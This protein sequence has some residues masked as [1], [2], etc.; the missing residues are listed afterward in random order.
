MYSSLLQ[1]QSVQY[2][3]ESKS[4]PEKMGSMTVELISEGA[5]EDYL[6]RELKLTEASVR[7]K[8]FIAMLMHD[9]LSLTPSLSYPPSFLPSLPRSFTPSS[10]LHPSPFPL[11]FTP[12]SSL[13]L[14]VA[15]PEQ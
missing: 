11:S 15:R 8:T 9:Y 4:S 10:L 1:E 14:R 7:K 6:I 5:Y 13:F 3:P 2:W 12:S